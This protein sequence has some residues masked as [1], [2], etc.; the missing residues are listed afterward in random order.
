MTMKR[1]TWVLALALVVVVAGWAAFRPERIWIDKKVNE[2][3]VMTAPAQAAAMPSQPMTLASGSFHAGAHETAGTATVYASAGGKRVLRLTGFH[4]S[5]G[6]DVRVYLVAAPDVMDNDTVKEAGFVDLGAL[7]GNI[8]DQN[9]EVPD[10]VDLDRFR[11][12]TVWCRR[13]AVNFGTAPLA[14]STGDGM[15]DGMMDESPMALASGSFRS[16]A[17]ETRGTATVYQLPG[18]KRVLRLTDFETS[19]GPDVRVYLVAA[20]EVLDNDTVKQA[21]FVELGA[22]KGNVGDQNYDVPDDVDLA[23]YRSVTIWCRRFAVNFA[24]ASLKPQTS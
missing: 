9:Y 18:G 7:K 13:F 5:N 15:M 3:L 1:R 11:S 24:S 23:M 19:N 6:P 21:G 22:L 2:E 12:V 17:H 16:V 20:P 14:A 10:D 4:T 8:G